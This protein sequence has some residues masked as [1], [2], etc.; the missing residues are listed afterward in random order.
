M[1]EKSSCSP[2][3]IPTGTVPPLPCAV[4]VPGVSGCSRACSPAQMASEGVSSGMW[5]EVPGTAS[6][7]EGKGTTCKTYLG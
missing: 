4:L 2:T 3:H 1:Q 7:L 6:S 5:D